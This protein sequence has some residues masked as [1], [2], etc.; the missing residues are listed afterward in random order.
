[1][2]EA[3]EAGRGLERAVIAGLEDEQR[4]LTCS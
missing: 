4:A 1:M 2:Q 3:L